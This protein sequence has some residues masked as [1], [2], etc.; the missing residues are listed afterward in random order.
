MGQPYA[1][2]R[3]YLSDAGGTDFRRQELRLERLVSSQRQNT[4]FPLSATRPFRRP[5][6]I[7]QRACRASSAPESREERENRARRDAAVTR[8]ALAVDQGQ[9]RKRRQGHSATTPSQE[10]T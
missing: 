5:N 8:W 10:A 2:H 6:R 1:V 7:G 4:G 3:R 9:N